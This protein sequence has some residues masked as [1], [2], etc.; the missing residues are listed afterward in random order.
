MSFQTDDVEEI[1]EVNMYM[2]IYLFIHLYKFIYKP[3]RPLAHEFPDGRCR[4]TG[5]GMSIYMHICIYA[6]YVFI[7]IYIYVYINI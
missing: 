5:R 3:G 2:F 6:I 7:F 4:R 1:D